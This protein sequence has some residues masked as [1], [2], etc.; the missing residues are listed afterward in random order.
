MAPGEVEHSLKAAEIVALVEED[1]RQVEQEIRAES[2]APVEAITAIGRHLHSGGGKRLRP[3]LLLLSSRLMG[4]GGARA[5]HLAAVIELIHSA[6]LV[7]DDVI[8][9]AHTRRGRPSPNVKWGNHTSVL[10]GDWLAEGAHL[11]VVGSNFLS[12][13]E[14]DHATLRR[15]AGECRLGF[16]THR[17]VEGTERLRTVLRD[18]APQCFTTH[19]PVEGTERHYTVTL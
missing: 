6:T 2:E 11:N 5:I 9:G 12:K 17:P 4:G 8:D 10:A 3:L 19:R 18:L 7:H 1:L 16:T 15:A 14:V 13:A